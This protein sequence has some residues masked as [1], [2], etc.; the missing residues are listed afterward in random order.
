MVEVVKNSRQF[1]TTREGSSFVLF[2]L[3]GGGRGVIFVGGSI[4]QCMPFA[5]DP[6]AYICAKGIPNL[7]GELKSTYEKN[8]NW[9]EKNHF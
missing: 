5:D 4:P 9:F 7:I 1:F 2:F 3:G 8:F 6:T